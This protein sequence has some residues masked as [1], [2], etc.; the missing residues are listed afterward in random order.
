MAAVDEPASPPAAK[1][2][3]LDP[4]VQFSA[5]PP[6]P[7]ANG[8]GHSD[9]NDVSSSGDAAVPV[10]TSAPSFE[11]VARGADKGKNEDY[12]SE[13]EEEVPEQ[14]VAEAEEHSRR[15]MYLDTVSPTMTGDRARLTL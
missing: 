7:Q 9:T 12:E 8:N 5:L 4:D 15:D 10:A 1:R 14:P 2:A 3:R 11:P 13:D 6:S